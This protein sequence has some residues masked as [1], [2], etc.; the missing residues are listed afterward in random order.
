MGIPASPFD[1]FPVGRG[2]RIQVSIMSTQNIALPARFFS[3]P[4]PHECGS[5]PSLADKL[6]KVFQLAEHMDAK[7]VCMLDAASQKRRPG[8]VAREY[9]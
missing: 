3:L 4:G 1:A 9:R 6:D 2:G 8:I 7:C 5:R